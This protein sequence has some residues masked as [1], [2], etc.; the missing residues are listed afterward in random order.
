MASW[1][2]GS[3]LS[4]S[5]TWEI[6]LESLTLGVDDAHLDHALVFFLPQL[7]PAFFEFATVLGDVFRAG[8]QR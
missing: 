3:S 5:L 6:F 1:R 2:F 7:V 4:Q 8:V